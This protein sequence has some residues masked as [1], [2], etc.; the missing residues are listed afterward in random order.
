[1][2]IITKTNVPV[3]NQTLTTH[4]AQNYFGMSKPLEN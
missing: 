1:M 3:L 4:Y 2:S